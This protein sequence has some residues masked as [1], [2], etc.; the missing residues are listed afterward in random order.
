MEVKV[1]GA[2]RGQRTPERVWLVVLLLVATLS[3][4]RDFA[5]LCIIH[6]HEHLLWIIHY[7]VNNNVWMEFVVG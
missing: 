3:S 2:S 6:T 7:A 5:S 4:C 1:S